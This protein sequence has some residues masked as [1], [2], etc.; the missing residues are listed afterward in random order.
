MDFFRGNA[1]A[2]RCT[3]IDA[4]YLQDTDEIE[5]TVSQENLATPVTFRLQNGTPWPA[6][7]AALAAQEVPTADGIGWKF[8]IQQQD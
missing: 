8:S 5:F 2:A 6:A 1:M 4:V 3:R 7:A